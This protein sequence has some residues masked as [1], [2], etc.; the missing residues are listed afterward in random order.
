MT[1]ENLRSAGPGGKE[2]LAC[3]LFGDDFVEVIREIRA[4]LANVESIRA[5]K[6]TPDANAGSIV[7][8]EA[9]LTRVV[10]RAL[11]YISSS[12]HAV[13][14]KHPNSVKARVTE[15]LDVEYIF[16]FASIDEL[17][18]AIIDRRVRSLSMRSLGEL[19]QYFR[20]TFEFD[21]F[22]S[23]EQR[24]S[25]IRLVAQRNLLV[26]NRGLVNQIYLEQTKDSR[27]KV[28][29]VIKYD[30]PK[31]L[32][33]LE[34]L[35]SWVCDLDVRLIEKFKLETQ[36]RAPRERI[37]NLGQW[38]FRPLTGPSKNPPKIQ[39]RTAPIR[40]RS[41]I[42]L[43]ARPKHPPVSRGFRREALWMIRPWIFR[44]RSAGLI[45]MPGRR[46][47]RVVMMLR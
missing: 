31:A 12:L 11:T 40:T 6:G 24:E 14:R 27:L 42:E 3:K 32:C 30:G 9:C 26:H 45:G 20:K 29:D 46:A 44:G 5:L 21:L 16:G 34:F 17:V 18:H 7:L 15:E 36:P 22:A 19:D 43:L 25:A 38:R 1:D 23:D 4:T 47:V 39:Y 35:S 8:F 2:T 28:G 13:C 33:A 10:D 37:E 41:W